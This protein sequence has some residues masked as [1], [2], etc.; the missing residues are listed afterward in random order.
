VK[1]FRVR[2]F[3]IFS[4]S[5]CKNALNSASEDKKMNIYH[6]AW[7][8]IILCFL[9]ILPQGVRTED[10][11]IL[12]PSLL[13]EMRISPP[14]PYEKIRLAP[15]RTAYV[16][17]ALLSPAIFGISLATGAGKFELALL[18]FVTILP[19]L[20]PFV[21][22]V[23]AALAIEHYRLKQA[24][25]R[26]KS[27]VQEL[28][29]RIPEPLLPGKNKKTFL[30]NHTDPHDR[31]PAII[32][33]ATKTE[34]GRE[35]WQQFLKLPKGQ[36]WDKDLESLINEYLPFYGYRSE[37]DT[38][39]GALLNR[40]ISVMTK[41]GSLSEDDFR[42]VEEGFRDPNPIVRGLA[43]ARVL[44]TR[45]PEW[46][47]LVGKL[48][49]DPRPVVRVAA[50]EALGGLV[51]APGVIELIEQA[52]SD[53]E[54]RVR[55]G[56]SI[57]IQ[58]MVHAEGDELPSGGRLAPLLRKALHDSD[59]TVRKI[60]ARLPRLHPMFYGLLHELLTNSKPLTKSGPFRFIPGRIDCAKALGEL[61]F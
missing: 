6:F 40:L 45:N 24:E 11:P 48:L 7:L 47:T 30:E 59:F 57:A 26:L 19:A 36:K 55:I 8:K 38:P 35:A 22:L 29:D 49:R 54:P 61:G 2:C 16:A 42:R 56:A 13:E 9:L 3:G 5:I 18:P 39:S 25:K 10:D 46:A 21:T 27:R 4:K 60:S 32:D 28:V 44:E 1:L 14:P 43:V 20:L 58:E 33:W 15:H 50:S 53:S 37:Q 23:P 41:S 31:L 12:E 52:L 17:S 51:S 34:D